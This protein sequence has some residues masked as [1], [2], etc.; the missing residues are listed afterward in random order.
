VKRI[1]L[2]RLMGV[3][4]IALLLNCA[5]FLVSY[6]DATI[7]FGGRIFVPEVRLVSPVTDTVDL[8]GKDN[9]DFEWSP[10]EGD[11]TKREYYDFRL[12][13][14]YQMLESTLIL[15]KRLYK[16]EDFLSIPSATFETGNVYTWSMRQVYMGTQKSLRSH[17]SFKVIR[18]GGQP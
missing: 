12:Y 2:S 9:L 15:K 18:K 4:I 3:T 8:T 10:H 11:R 1:L 16:D 6:S 5:P 17:S 13:K 7:L 14:G